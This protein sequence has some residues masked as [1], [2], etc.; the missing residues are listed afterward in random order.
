MPTVLQDEE[1]EI[2]PITSSVLMQQDP[3]FSYGRIKKMMRSHKW[4]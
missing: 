1:M 2:E 4:S 3:V